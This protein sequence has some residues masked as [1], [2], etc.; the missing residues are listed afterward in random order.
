MRGQAARTPKA[1]RPSI[2]PIP[3]TTCI[4]GGR[5][6]RSFVG[7]LNLEGPTR[8]AATSALRIAAITALVKADGKVVIPLLFHSTSPPKR[9]FLSVLTASCWSPRRLAS[10]RRA[11]GGASIAMGAVRIWRARPWPP[12]KRASEQRRRLRRRAI[13]APRKVRSPTACTN[14]DVAISERGHA[15]QRLRPIDRVQRRQRFQSQISTAA[16]GFT[17]RSRLVHTP[18]P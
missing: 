6:R 14:R 8:Q 2:S 15:L 9:A 1:R 13:P 12:S 5:F 4:Q 3:G 10:E 17:S 18:N 16:M 7:W 11:R